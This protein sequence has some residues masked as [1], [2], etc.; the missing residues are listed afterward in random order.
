MLLLVVSVSGAA[1]CSYWFRFDIAVWCLRS[2]FAYEVSCC[3]SRLGF[4]VCGVLFAACCADIVVV[5][6]CSL[7]FFCLVGSVVVVEVC[8]V[9]VAVC[10]LSWMLSAV[11]VAVDASCVSCV[12][13]V[14]WFCSCACNVD[15]CC[16]CLVLLAPTMSAPC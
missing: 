6:F 10:V 12:V 2:L 1:V 8:C 3:G 9:V 5:V 11:V 14:P 16:C 7:W 13:G 15:V 4:V